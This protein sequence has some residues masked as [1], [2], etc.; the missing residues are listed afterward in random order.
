M[1]LRTGVRLKTGIMTPALGDWVLGPILALI[2]DDK[3]CS[4]A[5]DLLSYPVG[6]SGGRR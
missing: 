1:V 2:C 5:N 6:H 3:R 4:R